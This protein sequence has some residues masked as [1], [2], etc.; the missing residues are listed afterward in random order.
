M[1]ELSVAVGRGL[2][3]KEEKTELD[4]LLKSFPDLVRDS[5]VIVKKTQDA[6]NQVHLEHCLKTLLDRPATD[7]IVKETQDA[8]ALAH[9]EHC[10][11]YPFAFPKLGII[12]DEFDDD[13]PDE[14]K[15]FL[16]ACR[17]DRERWRQYCRLRYIF[18]RIIQA[19]KE[20]ELMPE[21]DK[22][23]PSKSVDAIWEKFQKAMRKSK[24]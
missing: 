20:F 14:F 15:D 23:L 16:A 1:V 17:R 12:P 21:E 2:A 8:E 22:Q 19:N 5:K 6:E 9:R 10:L 4:L 18:E 13:E 24:R 3:N 11:N 7:V